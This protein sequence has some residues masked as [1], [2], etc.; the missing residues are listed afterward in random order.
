MLIE[1]QKILETHLEIEKKTE[2]HYE[3]D[4]VMTHE[5]QQEQ[6]TVEVVENLESSEIVVENEILEIVGIIREKPSPV[7]SRRNRIMRTTNDYPE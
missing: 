4:L 3:E 5:I 1:N 6:E 2:E 7:K